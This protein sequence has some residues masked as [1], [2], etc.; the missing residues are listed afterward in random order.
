MLSHLEHN[1]RSLCSN[2]TICSKASENPRLSLEAT[3]PDKPS[4]KHPRGSQI[5]W[6]GPAFDPCG[7]LPPCSVRRLHTIR[8]CFRKT[9]RRPR[10]QRLGH[11]DRSIHTCTATENQPPSP[12]LTASTLIEP[13]RGAISPT[14]HLEYRKPNLE[15]TTKLLLLAEVHA[16]WVG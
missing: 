13:R 3:I 9:C 4:L 6:P 2:V 16:I 7:H 5:E 15:G 14:C 10:Y 11:T 8:R 1:W 12:A